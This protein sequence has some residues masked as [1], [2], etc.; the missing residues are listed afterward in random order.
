[1]TDPA[2]KSAKERIAKIRENFEQTGNAAGEKRSPCR[3]H[4]RRGY[5]DGYHEALADKAVEYAVAFD[6]G[7]AS[8]RS[9][10][11]L[12]MDHAFDMLNTLCSKLG[13]TRED[14]ERL[15]R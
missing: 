6:A 4:Y 9:G 1:M 13:I 12:Q 10:L 5:A 7:R 11:Q 14:A 8:G 15:V 2:V 3:K